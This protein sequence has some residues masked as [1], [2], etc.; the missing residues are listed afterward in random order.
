MYD[1]LLQNGL[2]PDYDSGEMRISNVAIAGGK[3]AYVGKEAPPAKVHLDCSGKVISPGFID[4]HMHEDNFV[5]QGKCFETAVRMLEMGVTTGVGG[6]CGSLYQPVS[7]FKAVLNEL[8]GSPIHYMLLAG[9]NTCRETLGIGR[10]DTATPAQWKQIRALLQRELAEGA[11]GISFGIEYHP[12]IT[13]EEMV[14]AAGA[15]DDPELLVAAHYRADC[16]R[17]IAAVE[18]MV[19]YAAQIKQKF[20]ISHLSSCASYGTM[21]AA[22]ACINSAMA[23]N[24]RLN[25]DTYPYNAFGTGIGTTVFEDGC[26]E[27]WGRTYSDIILATEPYNGIRCTEEIFREAREKHP[28]TMAV[29]C[30]MREEDIRMA[31]ANKNGMIG[32][33][34]VSVGG[35][36]HPRTAGTFPRVLGKYVREEKVLPLI[37]A[38]RKMTREPARRMNLSRKG[39]LRVGFDAD[40]TVFDPE[41]IIDTADFLNLSKP[42]GIDCVFVGGGLAIDRGETVNKQL[43]RF[44]SC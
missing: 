41:T 29:A 44:L 34:G 30:V 12:G 39:E 3:I 42:K 18:E 13:F 20:Q 35:K 8:G 43:G 24:P 5:R 9:Y 23:R 10:Y 28:K 26:F 21:A 17:D 14:Y 37:D 16:L 38:L 36:G 22:L 7:E 6:N 11:C 27:A 32:S 31:L 19:E 4:I 2:C 40:I 25:Y 33:D 1:Y 15:S